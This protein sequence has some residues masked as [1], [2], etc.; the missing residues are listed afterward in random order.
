MLSFFIFALAILTATFIIVVVVIVAFRS[1]NAH[2]YVNL[3]LNH[4][5][6]PRILRCINVH[7][8]MLTPFNL[9][10]DLLELVRATPSNVDIWLLFALSVAFVVEYVSSLIYDLNGL[11][12][13]CVIF[14]FTVILILHLVILGLLIDISV[15]LILITFFII[16]QIHLLIIVKLLHLH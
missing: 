6:L 14:G 16:T 8:Y 12:I 15:L 7:L 11:G 9:L 4:K 2:R 3:F 5:C 13:V 1:E 10:L